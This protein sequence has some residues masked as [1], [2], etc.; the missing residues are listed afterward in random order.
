MENII[1][2]PAVEV[3]LKDIYQFLISECRYSYSRNNHLMPWGAYDHVKQYLPKMLKEDQ[4]WAIST[5][6]QLCEECISDE[7]VP[8]FSDGLDNENGSRKSA[9][10]FIE[11]LLDFINKNSTTGRWA[12]YNYRSY[13]ENIERSNNLKYG[14]YEPSDFS[15]DD[16][17]KDV[18]EVI[19]EN[20]T[21]KQCYDYLFKDILKTSNGTYNKLS[22]KENGRIVGYK[23]KIIDPTS[24]KDKLYMIK[25]MNTETK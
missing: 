16:L 8:N 7:L 12:P 1:R 2:Q 5:A 13:L 15:W 24:H 14:L 4:D 22:L 19:S 21:L 20:L 25:L 3:T 10:D 9:V 11:Y 18:K 6:K 23:F 17:N